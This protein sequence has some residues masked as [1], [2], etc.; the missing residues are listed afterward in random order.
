MQISELS[1]YDWVL[2]QD[3]FGEFKPQISYITELRDF[4][5]VSVVPI[6]GKQFVTDIKHIQPIE[7]TKDL[8]ELN[9]WEISDDN[10]WENIELNI[11]I[12]W[13]IQEYKLLYLHELQHLY[14]LR[15]LYT[16]ANRIIIR[17]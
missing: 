5:K 9:N 8:L 1:I 4:G 2:A 10:V 12:D 14:R 17:K 7:L 15:G 11:Y 16:L 6:D 3:M 13:K